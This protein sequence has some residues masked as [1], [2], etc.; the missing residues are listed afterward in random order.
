MTTCLF[1]YRHNFKTD[2][3]CKIKL[4]RKP[5]EG[6]AVVFVCNHHDHDLTEEGFTRLQTNKKLSPYLKEVVSVTLSFKLMHG[7]NKSSALHK[8]L[9]HLGHMSS[10]F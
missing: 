3:P 1:Y 4:K 10:V 5:N 9:S 6:L 2:C 7:S 8:F